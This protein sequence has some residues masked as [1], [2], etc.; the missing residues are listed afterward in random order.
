MYKS[1]NTIQN[2]QQTRTHMTNHTIIQIYYLQQHIYQIYN[3][4]IRYH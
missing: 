1:K 3:K 2:Y 4:T